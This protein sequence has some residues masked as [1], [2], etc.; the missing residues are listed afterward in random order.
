MHPTGRAIT[1]ALTEAELQV[2]ACLDVAAA[3][4]RRAAD[5]GPSSPLGRGWA[6]WAG[7]LETEAVRLQGL[8][9]LSPQR[10]LQVVR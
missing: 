6:H 1:E 2:D 8:D 3:M 7:R 9:D 4:R 10:S 5:F